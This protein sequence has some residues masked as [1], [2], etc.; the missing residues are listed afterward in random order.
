MEE[1][2]GQQKRENL[3][4]GKPS[5]NKDEERG[6]NRKNRSSSTI[7]DLAQ[8][9]WAPQMRYSRDFGAHPAKILPGWEFKSSLQSV[10]GHIGGPNP[11]A[12]EPILVPT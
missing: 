11:L 7:Q 4:P 1:K 12:N 5:P 10:A 8:S 6:V 9:G 2:R 3:Y